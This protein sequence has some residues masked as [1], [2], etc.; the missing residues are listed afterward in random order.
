MAPILWYLFGDT[1]C[2]MGG[3]RLGIDRCVTDALSQPGV[4]AQAVVDDVGSATAPPGMA[5]I[6][7]GVLATHPDRWPGLPR[8]TA[9]DWPLGWQ[10]RFVGP[11]QPHVDALIFQPGCVAFRWPPVGGGSLGV[12]ITNVRPIVTEPHTVRYGQALI[13]AADTMVTTAAGRQLVEDAATRAGSVDRVD[14]LAI[15]KQIDRDLEGA[16]APPSTFSAWISSHLQTIETRV[17]VNA[18]G[19]VGL[20]IGWVEVPDAEGADSPPTV[21]LRSYPCGGFT[22]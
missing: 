1:A 10:V 3:G 2:L 9:A 16:K 20:E 19:G 7:A 6:M 21:M 17:C 14:A 5:G 11:G 13:Q 8:W 4:D 22:T 15:L 18:Q 12:D